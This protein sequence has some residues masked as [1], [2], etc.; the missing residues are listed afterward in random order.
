MA[1]GITAGRAVR[2]R[3]IHDIGFGVETSDLDSPAWPDPQTPTDGETNTVVMESP[4]SPDPNPAKN[5]VLTS[6][7]PA[8]L[9]REYDLEF[10]GYGVTISPVASDTD[11]LPELR[12][13]PAV[14]TLSKASASMGGPRSPTPPTASWS[15]SSDDDDGDNNYRGVVDDCADAIVRHVRCV[16]NTAC[17]ARV[18]NEVRHILASFC[19]KPR[20]LLFW[21]I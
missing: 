11:S 1:D 15:W 14:Q 17:R 9:E 2:S 12:F 13:T 18:A 10:C 4:A 6:T 19:E 16:M 21:T 5:N 7:M 8:P 20:S 3:G